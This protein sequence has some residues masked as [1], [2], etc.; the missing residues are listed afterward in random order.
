M[1]DAIETW[2]SI[3]KVFGIRFHAQALEENLKKWFDPGQ[4]QLPLQLPPWCSQIYY[5]YFFFIIPFQE[6]AGFPLTF[7]FPLKPQASADSLRG[8]DVCPGRGPKLKTVK[9]QY[10]KF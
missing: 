1:T 3:A 8:G 4:D 9:V 10:P 2:I 5:L 7:C 6:L